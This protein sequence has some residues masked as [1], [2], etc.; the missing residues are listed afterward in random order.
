MKTPRPILTVHAE[1][2][3]LEV[4]GVL[5]IRASFLSE[6]LFDERAGGDP[7]E[8]DLYEVEVAH[9]GEGLLEPITFPRLLPSSPAGW[10]DVATDDAPLRLPMERFALALAW[11]LAQA[12]PSNWSRI[13][14]LAR[15]WDSWGID[16]ALGHLPPGWTPEEL[17]PDDD[18]M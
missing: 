14:E 13:C 7:E 9:A 10:E 15:G 6:G 8:E 17:T 1:D 11:E 2:V 5:T 18:L 16:D 12:D 4:P 3:D